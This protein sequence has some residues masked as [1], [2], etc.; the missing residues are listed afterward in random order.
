[1]AEE[2][3]EYLERTPKYAKDRWDASFF[4]VLE[5][6]KDHYGY[7][8]VEEWQRSDKEGR[9]PRVYGRTRDKMKDMIPITAKEY[10]QVKRKCAEQLLA[11]IPPDTPN[12]PTAEK[13]VFKERGPS[14]IKAALRHL[15]FLG[16]RGNQ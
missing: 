7:K 10:N 5:P 2:K 3:I 4:K 14:P 11:T 16:N 13:P 15:L 12:E 1:M 8:T 9:C 6:S